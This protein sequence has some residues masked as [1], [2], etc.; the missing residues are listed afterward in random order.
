MTP[1]TRFVSMVVPLALVSGCSW[2]AA[3]D[4]YPAED[5]ALLAAVDT[6]DSIVPPLQPG[7]TRLESRD[8]SRWEVTARLGDL[9]IERQ[10]GPEADPIGITWVKLKGQ[11]VFVD[12]LNY[13]IDLAALWPIGDGH[14]IAL[15]QVGLG[16][17]G[18]PVKHRILELRYGK[19]VA[20]TKEFGTCAEAPDT[21]WFDRTG[22]LRMR[23]SEY[24]AYFVQLEPDYRQGPPS[25][26]IYR[27]GG[28][29]EY[30]EDE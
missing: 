3:L 5:E 30:A 23:F 2:G 6:A 17:T 16:G 15:L 28:R 20:I 11:T 22:A 25:T 8:S 27:R 19:P 9:T 14:V 10:Y 24:A 29:L 18:C 7:R 1:R 4:D 12:S 26:W 21:M 13:G